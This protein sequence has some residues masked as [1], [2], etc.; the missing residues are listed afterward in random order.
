MVSDLSTLI[1]FEN[2][3]LAVDDVSS[4]V[5]YDTVYIP[6]RS[7][8]HNANTELSVENEIMSEPYS[9]QDTR[10]EAKLNVS[11]CHESFEL[12]VGEII[13][14]GENYVEAILSLNKCKSI[15]R[16]VRLKRTV[17]KGAA[18]DIFVGAELRYSYSKV[19]HSIAKDGERRIEESK[20]FFV[21]KLKSEMS[22]VD[23][24][25]M[26]RRKVERYSYL[27][28]KNERR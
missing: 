21:P 7:C 15:R 12:W 13:G 25:E 5:D 16:K 8:D 19:R 27:F 20:V 3:E 23:F 11:D 18:E 1:Q 4:A 9:L 26:V 10:I 28:S 2:K 14:L 17:I 6:K 24:D 22:S